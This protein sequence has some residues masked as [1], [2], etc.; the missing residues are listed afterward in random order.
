MSK[1]LLRIRK[2]IKLLARLV[3]DCLS[4]FKQIVLI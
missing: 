4:R 2:S 1:E 3:A